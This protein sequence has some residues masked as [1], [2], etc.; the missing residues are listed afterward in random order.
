MYDYFE[1]ELSV[2]RKLIDQLQVEL[3]VSRKASEEFKLEFTVGKKAMD[4]T[5]T[6]VEQ[7]LGCED[8]EIPLETTLEAEI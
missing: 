5:R 7:S 1:R 3:T 8:H 4:P 2:C 6:C